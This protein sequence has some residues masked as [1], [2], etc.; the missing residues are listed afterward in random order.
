[1]DRIS[2]LKRALATLNDA[3]RDLYART[4][5]L[6]EEELH[7]KPSRDA[8]SVG[9]V[10]DHII[11][12]E[13][14]FAADLRKKLLTFGDDPVEDTLI[15]QVMRPLI[16]TGMRYAGGLVKFEA[17]SDLRPVL[18]Y[19]HLYLVYKLAQ[20]REATFDVAERLARREEMVYMTEPRSGTLFSGEDWLYL[21]GLHEARHVGQVERVL[22]VLEDH[23]EHRRA[24]TNGVHKKLIPVAS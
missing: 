10:M 14:R 19:P 4:N 22:A 9:Q 6:T 20:V 23:R 21:I 1:M 16:F 7:F 11:K 17:A 12:F 24:I 13:A 8:W 18:G 15:S 2:H 3:R 5:A